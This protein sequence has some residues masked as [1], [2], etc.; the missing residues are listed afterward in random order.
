[1]IA[2]FATFR[3]WRQHRAATRADLAAYRAAQ[4]AAQGAELELGRA[5]TATERTEL[6]ADLADQYQ[7]LARLHPT[8]WGH[9]HRPDG[10]GNWLN[11]QAI[12]DASLVLMLLADVEVLHA[13]AGGGPRVLVAHHDAAVRLPRAAHDLLDRMAAA[14]KLARRLELLDELCDVLEEAIGADAARMV[15]NLPWP[16]LGLC[17][18]HEDDSGEWVPR[19]DLTAF[20]LADGGRGWACPECLPNLDPARVPTEE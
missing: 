5:Y 17:W 15:R 13:G 3:R 9:G 18:L 7:T 1:M 20:R 11:T 2:V 6:L 16:A 10:R 19:P 8:V 12:A 4:S 14:D